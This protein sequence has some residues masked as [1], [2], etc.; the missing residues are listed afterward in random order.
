[1]EPCTDIHIA[2]V[3]R[4]GQLNRRTIGPLVEF[5]KQLGGGPRQCFPVPVGAQTGSAHLAGDHCSPKLWRTEN[6]RDTTMFMRAARTLSILE[7]LQVLS[8]KL[9]EEYST[10]Q[11]I[12]LSFALSA[13][14]LEPEVRSSCPVDTLMELRDLTV[15]H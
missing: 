4:T 3:S 11:E 7:L 6:H 12:P 2:R 10:M 8:E 14:S 1:M 15:N 5:S 9:S 13:R